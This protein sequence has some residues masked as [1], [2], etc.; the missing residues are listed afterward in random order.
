MMEPELGRTI[1]GRMMKPWKMLSKYGSA[2]N[3]SVSV[4][5]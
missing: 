5:N 1:D 3:H 2:L 4:L